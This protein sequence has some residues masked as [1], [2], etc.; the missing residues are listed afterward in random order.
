MPGTPTGRRARALAVAFALCGAAVEARAGDGTSAAPRVVEIPAE[1][2][3]GSPEPLRV[4]L[5]HLWLP[6]GLLDPIGDD[7]ARQ[8]G[9]AA[10][11]SDRRFRANTGSGF[12]DERRLLAEAR[13]ELAWEISTEITGGALSQRLIDDDEIIARHPATLPEDLFGGRT[14]FSSDTSL[15]VTGAANRSKTLSL[16]ASAT[17]RRIDD[18]P[19]GTLAT[20]SIARGDYGL[21]ARW[22]ATPELRIDAGTR[23]YREGNDNA[24]LS[25]WFLESASRDRDRDELVAAARVIWQPA[26]WHQFEATVDLGAY[27]DDWRPRGGLSEPGHSNLDTFERWGNHPF[28]VRRREARAFARLEWSAFT[29]GVLSSS[30]SHTLHVGLDVENV[31]RADDETRTGGFTYVD[32]VP[33]GPDGEFAPR[34]DENDRS[35]WLLFSSDRGDELHADIDHASLA[36]WIEERFHLGDRLEIEAGA[37]LEHFGGGFADRPGS[38][39]AF[40]VAPRLSGRWW[41]TENGATSLYASAGRHYQRMDET[42][43]VRDRVGAAYSPLEYWDWTGDPSQDPLPGI[44]DPDWVR[45]AQFPAFVGAIDPD[46]EHPH[47]DRLVA[48]ATTGDPD[49]GLEIEARYELRVHR[50]MLG[51][52]DA[53]FSLFDPNSK[54]E[55]TY[56]LTEETFTRVDGGVETATFYDLRPGVRPDY[57][58]GNPPG[59]RRRSHQVDLR[60]RSNLGRAFTVSSSLRY[61]VDRGNFDSSRG[62]SLE[63]RD[64]SGTLAS[65]GNMPGIDRFRAQLGATWRAPLLF[66]VDVDYRYFS[67]AYYSRVAR[68]APTVAPR[69]NVFDGRGR[70]GYRYPARHR[71]SARL[72]R[73]VPWF[74]PGRL[75]MWVR[76]Q[77][78]LGQRPVTGFREQARFF[79]SVRRLDVPLEIFVGVSHAY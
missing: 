14:V 51:L 44:A 45:R 18:R 55:G 42:F 20:Q 17:D 68:V 77:N 75:R 60:L 50:A 47:I 52:Y 40:T 29:D 31:D 21:S 2:R 53:G 12:T 6:D 74:G 71:L 69:I 24:G 37:R 63:W 48:G 70:G 57:T 8:R 34:I 36:L 78:L 56:E 10:P 76:G 66:N 13:P 27:R 30:D 19:L 61:A 38:W 62:L 65:F 4:P 39:S 49:R 28:R 26:Y 1:A 64:P 23:Y 22:D 33:V 79:E 15:W 58:I 16:R 54:P 3:A 35:T 7:G 73:P 11:T 67:G 59:A 5:S 46:A 72:S 32:I 9:V 41:L 43:V 25:Q